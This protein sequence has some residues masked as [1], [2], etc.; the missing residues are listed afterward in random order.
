[1]V[2][3]TAGRVSIGS[4][5]PESHLTVNA[6]GDAVIGTV[7][8]VIRTAG[9]LNAY[10]GYF[11]AVQGAAT[12]IPRAVGLYTQT[13]RSSTSATGLVTDAIGLEVFSLIDATYGVVATNNYGILISNVNNVNA[14]NNYALYYNFSPS[15]FV[16]TGAGNVGVGTANPQK[17]L[18]VQGDIN[19]SGN[20][21]AKYQ[22]IAEW[23]PASAD[24]P[25]GTVVVLD[26]RSPNTVHAS[27]REYD[28]TV[29]GVISPKPGLILGEDGDGKELV[30]TTGRVRVRVDASR[31]PIRIGDLL[32][33][34]GKAGLAMRSEPMDINGRK[35][36][37]PGTILGKALE[38]LA[39]GEGEILVLLSLQ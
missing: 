3:D 5:P 8:R 20:I 2:I 34:S 39:N 26:P 31:R 24:L 32:V 23:V 37:Q 1:M 7:S 35:F 21:N 36:H 33:T 15:P 12:A 6:S 22:D 29:A 11:A 27:A 25:P 16:I 13:Y 28:E 17:K 30:A 10:G 18:D 14:L 4:A 38:P 9:A 19:V